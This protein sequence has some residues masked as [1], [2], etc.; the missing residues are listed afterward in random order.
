MAVLCGRLRERFPE[1]SVYNRLADREWAGP[2][3]P[4]AACGGIAMMR[5]AAFAAVGGFNAG[6]VAGEEPELCARLRAA[7]WE[8]HRLDAEMAVHDIDMTRFAQ[9]WRRTRRG[10]FAAAQGAAMHGSQ[11]QR[12][13]RG[14]A[15]VWGLVLPGAVLAGLL[16]TP[17]A[18]ALLLALPTQVVRLAARSGI[19]RRESWEWAFF[20]TLGKTPEALGVLDYALRRLTGRAGR[21][22]EYR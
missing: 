3:G 7:G 12:A 11:R 2:V 4:V 5:C 1:R 15:V 22:I 16:V 21:L 6:L 8:I 17:W 19:G 10:G 14:R 18:L 20:M 9:W 13:Q